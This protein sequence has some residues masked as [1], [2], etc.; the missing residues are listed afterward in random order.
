M[1]T[2]VRTLRV[3]TNFLTLPS[4]EGR[5]TRA[6]KRQRLGLLDLRQRLHLGKHV[7]RHRT[8]DL[9]Q[10]DGITALLVA[11]EMEGRD[12]DLGVAEQTGEMSDESRLVLLGDIDH[13][14]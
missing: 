4:R 10:R 9:D 13:P 14:S 6:S 1:S 11:A 5:S 12:V 2:V 7:R 8:V 3:A